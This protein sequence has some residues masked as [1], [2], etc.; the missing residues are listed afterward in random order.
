[1]R[2]SDEQIERFLELTAEGHNRHQA[3][4]ILAQE[5][6]DKRITATRLRW[7]CNR[8][9]VLKR[10]YEQAVVEGRGPLAERLESC[11]VE[12][13]LGGHW[14]ALKFLLSTYGEQFFWARSAKVELSGTVE[15]QAIAG[16]L[17][18][19]LPQDMYEELMREVEQRMLEETKA[20][21]QAN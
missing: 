17:A 9:P 20:L 4:Q 19:Y 13:A 14:P 3:A 15:L 2:F 11:A 8:D 1:M 21:P 16:I 12:M 10:R 18:R 5:Y 7:A 6:D